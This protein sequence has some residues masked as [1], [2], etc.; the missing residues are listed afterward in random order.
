MARHFPR[1]S[2]TPEALFAD[3]ARARSKRDTRAAVLVARLD[4]AELARARAVH[5]L[6][7]CLASLLGERLHVNLGFRSFRALL[8]ARGL[9]RSQAWK[10][11]ALARHS[12]PARIAELGIE[13]AYA[14]VAPGAKRAATKRGGTK[15]G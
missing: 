13:G 7:A 2:I 8:A 11:M 5:A 14:E 6:G 12:T 9:G 15:R 3:L 4:R 10:L 1:S